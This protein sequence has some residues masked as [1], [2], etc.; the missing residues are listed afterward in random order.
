MLSL[1]LALNN[2]CKSPLKRDEGEEGEEEVDK[3]QSRSTV[4]FVDE[5]EAVIPRQMILR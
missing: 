1:E 2:K 3:T 4:R 5:E